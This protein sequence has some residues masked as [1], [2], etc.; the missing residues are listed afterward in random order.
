VQGP[1]RF[2]RELRI[3]LPC[4]VDE[5]TTARLDA[6]HREFVNHEVYYLSSQAA[7]TTFLLEP[8]VYTGPVTDPV[9]LERFQPADGSPRRRHR[10]RL[11]YFAAE[12]TARLFDEAPARYSE[13]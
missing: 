1:E 3:E 4:V 5:T 9:T 12:E 8:H 6:D 2:L 7:R 13:P 11:F 10:G